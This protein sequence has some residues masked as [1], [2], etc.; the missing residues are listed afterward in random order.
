MSIV[1]KP[2][3]WPDPKRPGG[4][5]VAKTSVARRLPKAA[6]RVDKV[7]Q[8][9]RGHS[10]RQKRAGPPK[11]GGSIPGGLT[12]T[13]AR[14]VLGRM[15]WVNAHGY[16]RACSYRHIAAMAEMSVAILLE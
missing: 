2:L 6:R 1:I 3:T 13:K 11:S 7:H 15:A 9:S 16:Q 4:D 14:T 8:L 10:S 12:P 5:H